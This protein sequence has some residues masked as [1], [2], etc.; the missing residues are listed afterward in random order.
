MTIAGFT[1]QKQ[2]A[3]LSRSR[4]LRSRGMHASETVKVELPRRIAAVNTC[5]AVYAFAQHRSRGMPST[6]GRA[7]QTDG[8][9]II[10]PAGLEPARAL[11]TEHN[12]HLT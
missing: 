7:M 12:A 2:P 10:C 5:A 9:N 8:V 6:L 4:V 1:I 11:A 3:Y